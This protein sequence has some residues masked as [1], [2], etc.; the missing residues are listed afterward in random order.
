MPKL[1]IL[2]SGFVQGVGFRKAT[3][4]QARSLGLSG[5]VKN[6]PDGRVEIFASGDTES[7]ESLIA[8]SRKGPK[9]AK[10][11]NVE[12][13]QSPSDGSDEKLAAFEIE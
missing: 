2:V 8:W 4:E 3:C 12:V 11:E 5:R 6:L 7:L 1:K 13:S 9:M 10:V